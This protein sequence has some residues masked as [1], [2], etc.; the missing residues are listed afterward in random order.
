GGESGPA[1]VPGNPQESLLLDA[2]KHQTF[3]M[4][5]DKK[6]PAN[7][8]VLIEK[9]ISMGAPD[10]RERKTTKLDR[11]AL[12]ALQPITTP[13]V[14]VVQGVK[15]SRDDLDAFILARLEKQGLS[16]VGDADRYTLL[17]RVTFDLTGLPPTPQEIAAFANDTSDRAFQ[18]VVDRLLENPGFG[19]RWARHWFD[20]SC[21]ADLADI[22]GNVLIRDAWRYRDYV[23][24]ALNSDK[25]LDQFIREQIA[26]DLLPY[27]NVAQQ[28][29]QIIATGYLA[30]GP[31][32]LQNY[33]KGQLAA[34]VVDHQIDRIGRTFLAQTISCARCHDHKFDPV[35]TADY[36][37]LAGIFHSTRTTSYD[38]PGVWSQITHVTLPKLPGADT[39]YQRF[40]R[41]IDKQQQK[42]RDELA[43]LQRGDQKFRFTKMA[44]NGQ[45]NA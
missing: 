5:P 10:P 13:V 22:Q 42:L 19:D 45:A 36:Y 32:T 31:W 3:E 2:L 24:H 40:A 41:E 9:W 34:D 25:P 20:V 8:I 29:E 16:P 30:I 7:E 12:W 21:Y 4:P 33:I 11:K 44:V 23:V 39:E 14:P 15:W 17:R 35:S 1:I 18:T 27:E 38:G 6:L 37:A 43:G 28:R 26:G